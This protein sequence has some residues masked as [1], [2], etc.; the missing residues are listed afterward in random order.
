MTKLDE[1]LVH[2]TKFVE[3]KGYEPFA[4]SNLPD[5]RLVV[6]S[7]MDTRLTELLPKAM[8]LRN[9]DAKFIKNAGAVVTHPY[10]SVMRSIL[11]AVYELTAD[12][13]IVVGHHGCGMSSLNAA[14]M[15]DKMRHRGVSEDTLQQVNEQGVHLNSW[16]TGFH[17]I[18]ES[19]Q[20]TVDIIRSHPLLPKD[21]Y[22]HGLVVDPQTGSLDVVD[23]GYVFGVEAN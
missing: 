15:L 14:S 9:G 3:E 12:E 21:V 22:V 19:I 17:D 8:N 16:L 6:L 5:K 10:G 2:N 18:R 7:C 1:I 13:V 23:S 4:T 11:V 20:D